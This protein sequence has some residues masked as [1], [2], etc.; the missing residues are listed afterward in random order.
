MVQGGWYMALTGKGREPVAHPCLC[1]K[2]EKEKVKIAIRK[3]CPVFLEHYSQTLSTDTM[4]TS[5]E[6]HG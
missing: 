1:G 2:T 3:K 6:F 4:N 5:E